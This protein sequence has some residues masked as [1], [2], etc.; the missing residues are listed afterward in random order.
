MST[1]FLT[2]TFRLH[3]PYH[4]AQFFC[5]HPNPI[6]PRRQSLPTTREREYLANNFV[7]RARGRSLAYTRTTAFSLTVWQLVVRDLT[8]KEARRRARWR[9]RQAGDKKVLKVRQTDKEVDE[10]SE[11]DMPVVLVEDAVT[12]DEKGLERLDVTVDFDMPKWAYIVRVNA[13]KSVIGKRAVQRNRAKRRIRAAAS[14]VMPAH[15]DRGKEYTFSA[16]PEALTIAHP[17]LVEEVR[18][19]L[20][21]VGC[22]VE[23]TTLDM[24]KRERY[25]KW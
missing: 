23:E 21:N 25:C 9:E 11:V 17:D 5:C 4:H 14:E 3:Y 24:V 20:K 18:L 6:T 7:D 13:G 16:N 12:A 10:C 22:W 1:A 19:A 8:E 15:A 2:P